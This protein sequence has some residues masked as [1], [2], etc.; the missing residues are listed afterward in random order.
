MRPFHFAVHLKGNFDVSLFICSV[1]ATNQLE[2][3]ER[4]LP[5]LN[6]DLV[7]TFLNRRDRDVLEQPPTQEDSEEEA[8]LPYTSMV[9]LGIPLEEPPQEEAL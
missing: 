7:V 1:Q 8:K 6:R 2:A 3:L 4:I 9:A 5:H